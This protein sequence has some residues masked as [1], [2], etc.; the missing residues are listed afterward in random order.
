MGIG[1]GLFLCPRNI[2]LLISF[3]FQDG[4]E[5]ISHASIHNGRQYISR[6]H[7]LLRKKSFQFKEHLKIFTSQCILCKFWR[8]SKFSW[9]P[10]PPSPKIFQCHGPPPLLKLRRH[11]VMVPYLYP[12]I[13]DF[14]GPTQKWISET[15]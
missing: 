10:L 8:M 2:I 3:P 4:N 9:P 1:K 7:K 5:V 15:V 13:F 14:R 6:L 11:L 12:I